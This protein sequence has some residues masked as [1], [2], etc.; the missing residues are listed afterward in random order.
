MAYD[1]TLAVKYD[2]IDDKVQFPY[3]K[4]E[5]ADSAMLMCFRQS[6]IEYALLYDKRGN[7]IASIN[8][9]NQGA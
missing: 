3:I 9:A 2:G 7:C 1:W 5:T 4:R 6:G 8:N